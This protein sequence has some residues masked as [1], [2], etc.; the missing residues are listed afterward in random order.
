M[1][2]SRSRTHAP[3][4]TLTPASPTERGG[5]LLIDGEVRGTSIDTALAFIHEHPDHSLA[6]IRAW[7]RTG[8]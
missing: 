6:I 4:T 2:H 1:V 5:A 3:T 7:L 8:P